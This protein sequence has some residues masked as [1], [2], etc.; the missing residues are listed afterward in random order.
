MLSKNQ[1]SKSTVEMWMF[2]T[3]GLSVMVDFWGN[4]LQCIFLQLV[5]VKV[6]STNIFLPF[7]S[8]T[9]CRGK[10]GVHYFVIKKMGFYWGSEIC[11]GLTETLTSKRKT[12]HNHDVTCT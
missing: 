6:L 3:Y 5:A 11:D 8:L 1:S 12:S 7:P 10:I 4:C 2:E 9:S